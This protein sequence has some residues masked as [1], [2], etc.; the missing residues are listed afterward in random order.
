MVLL[1]EGHTEREDSVRNGVHY[2]IFLSILLFVLDRI[3][4]VAALSALGAAIP[5]PGFSFAVD[6]LLLTKE[7]NF[8]RSKL[9]LPKEN[10][11]EFRR[12]TPENQEKIRKFC[13]T[14]AIQTT[15]LVAAY[16][17]SSALEETTRYIP[18]VG[19]LIAG[20][21][22]FSSTYSFLHQ[23]LSELEETAMAFLDIKVI[24]EQG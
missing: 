19:S 7:V 9:G 8:Y 5:L 12:M 24:I 23:C 20:S 15:S 17:A 18:C 22:S 16:T 13:L 21:I 1:A 4:T 3:S 14:S 6:V 10:S 2:H 11:Y